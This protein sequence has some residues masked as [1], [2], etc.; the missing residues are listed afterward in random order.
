MESNLSFN[1]I[2]C[3]FVGHRFL[4]NY[5]HRYG[6]YRDSVNDKC[7]CCGSKRAF[8]FDEEKILNLMEKGGMQ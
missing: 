4:K 2:K 3:M 8:N 5:N 7:A 6:Y 1:K